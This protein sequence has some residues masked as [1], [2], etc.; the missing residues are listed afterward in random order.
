MGGKKSISSEEKITEFPKQN[1]MASCA[2]V[3]KRKFILC[4]KVPLLRELMRVAGK[5]MQCGHKAIL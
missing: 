3:L 5:N 1:F 2:K 4:S